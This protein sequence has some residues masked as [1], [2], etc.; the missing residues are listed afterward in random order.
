MIDPRQIK[1][2]DFPLNY[3]RYNHV[4]DELLAAA[5]GFVHLDQQGWPGGVELDRR[6]MRIRADLNDI[7]S[8]IQR[9]EERLIE[10]ADATAAVPRP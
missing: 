1:T 6:I 10:A 4:M 5:K 8:Q 3:D 9:T 7:W 2:E